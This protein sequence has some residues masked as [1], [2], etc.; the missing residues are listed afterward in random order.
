[1]LSGGLEAEVLAEA[2]KT[3]GAVVIDVSSGV[4]DK[5]GVKSPER[6]K[7]FLEAARRL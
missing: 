2:V 7:A 3:S 6:I 5:P 1:M 4:E